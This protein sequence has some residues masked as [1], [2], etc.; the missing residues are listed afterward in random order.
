MA[1]RTKSGAARRGGGL[2]GRCLI[3]MVL[4]GAVAGC[5]QPGVSR[6]LLQDQTTSQEPR[7]GYSGFTGLRGLLHP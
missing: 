4:L 2:V 6:M 1:D 7:L 5:S 3:G